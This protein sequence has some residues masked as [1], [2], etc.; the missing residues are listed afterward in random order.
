M[1]EYGREYWEEHQVARRLTP[2]DLEEIARVHAER[3][4]ALALDADRWLISDTCALTTRAFALDYHGG[5]SP[6]LS[7]A[8]DACA[9]RYDLF[10]LCGDDIPFEDTWDRSGPQ[11]R[12]DFQRLVE[13]DLLERRIPF[14]PL[15]GTLEER[16]DTAARAIAGFEK[17]G[18]YFGM[19]ASA[20]L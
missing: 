18:N 14:I 12:S 11:K 20:G 3:E 19:A 16:L 2:G 5:A 1:P 9:R 7:A 4:D 10:F 15:L 13:A 6:R 8:A 17:F